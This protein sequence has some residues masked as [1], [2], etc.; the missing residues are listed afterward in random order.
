MAEDKAN[1]PADGPHRGS[2]SLRRRLGL[3]GLLTLVISLGLVGLAL[4]AA[5][6]VSA[7]ADLRRQMETWAYL[8]LAATEIAPDS[9]LKVEDDLGDPAL[10]QPGS[11]VYALVETPRQN[12]QSSSALGQTL[13]ELTLVEP[14][15][16]SFTEPA[17][18]ARFF[19]FQQGLAWELEESLLLPFTVS[20]V[21]EQSQLLPR[22]KAFRAGLWR[23]LGAVGLL[24]ALVQLLFLSLS[25]RPFRQI[26]SDVAQIERGERETLRGDYPQELEPLTRNLQRLLNTEKSSQ[27]R[28]RN[29]LDSLAHSLKTPLA[30]ISSR[31]AEGEDPAI[32][33]AVS[34]MQHLIGTRLQRAAA[35]TRRTLGAPVAVEPLA[36]RLG[37]ALKRVHS[38]T[39]RTLELNIEPGLMFYGE[40][41]DLLEV[42]GNLLE[43]ACK[44]GDGQV[45]LSAGAG[46]SEQ[47]RPGLWLKV[48]N[49]GSPVNLEPFLARGVRGDEHTEGQGL[50]L[51]IVSEVVSAYEGQLRFSDSKRGG[52]CVEVIF[53]AQ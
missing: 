6:R 40:E 1:L 34:D 2:V 51:A 3:L 19:V 52:V 31:A 9:R 45:R 22:L 28:Y 29:A 32:N 24:L 12:F 49:N 7:E 36:E 4:D 5:Y 27:K 47:N 14:G 53:P 15:T 33:E 20:I 21:V 35:N 46:P 50:G 8:T 43:N 23:S 16:T 41:R 42:M 48:E 10:G 44:Y 25:L 26:A 18:D 30:V 13:P 39:L 17:P 37:Q 11:G 38:H